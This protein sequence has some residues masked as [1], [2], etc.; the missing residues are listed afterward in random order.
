[1][2]LDFLLAKFSWEI[3]KDFFIPIFK[4]HNFERRQ[5]VFKSSVSVLN[6]LKHFS[7]LARKTFKFFSLQDHSKPKKKFSWKT[8]HLEKFTFVHYNVDESM[9]NVGG[10]VANLDF[11]LKFAFFHL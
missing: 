2:S 7:L 6:I 5:C 11:E 9:S 8:S 10:I 1:M 3:T 4:N